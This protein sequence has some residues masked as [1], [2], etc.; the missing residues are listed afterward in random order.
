MF[1]DPSKQ[2]VMM[3]AGRRPYWRIP[4]ISTG[5]KSRSI[6]YPYQI[7][8]FDAG[9]LTVPR[10]HAEEIDGELT[11]PFE[12]DPSCETPRLKIRWRIEIW[13]DSLPSHLF[14]NT[15]YLRLIS[16]LDF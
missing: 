13:F 3:G 10:L 8:F 14:L 12:G 6:T 11:V 7:N 15:N 4:G 5:A 2:V 16:K 9:P 1:T